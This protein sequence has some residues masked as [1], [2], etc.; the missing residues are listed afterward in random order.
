ME[1]KVIVSGKIRGR[2]TLAASGNII[3]GDDLT[4]QTDPGAGG[5]ADVA[6]YFS[7]ERVV[8]SN[9]LLNAPARVPGHSAYYTYD[10]SQAEFLHGVVLALDIFTA[11]NY[12]SGSTSGQPCGTARAGRGCLYLTGGIIQNAPGAVGLGDGR[13]YVERYSYD[14]CAANQPPPYF[15]TTGVFVKGQYSQVDPAG[16]E[17]ANFFSLIAPGPSAPPPF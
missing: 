6:G 7:G 16:F 10:D 9:N 13:G 8:L 2:V 1:G 15:P 14:R 4:Y 11:E 12:T 5:C 3:V 17:I